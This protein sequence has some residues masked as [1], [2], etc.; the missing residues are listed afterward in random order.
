MAIRRVTEPAEV[1]VQ[2]Q[3]MV[4]ETLSLLTPY[5]LP[6]ERKVRIGEPGDGSYVIVDRLHK[7]QPVMSFGVGP[8][9]NFEIGMAERGHNVFMF[10]H[11]IAEPP[12]AHPRAVWFC[13]GVAST[14]NAPLRL[15]T[16]AEHMNKLP[17]GCEPPILKMDIE[18]DEWSVL[19]SASPD[20]L[21]R[22]DQITFELHGLERIEDP[23]FNVIARKVFEILAK[24]FTL[25]HVHANNFCTVRVLAGCFPVP[26]ALEL[27]YI[28]SSLVT[29]APSRTIYPTELDAP[30]F[31][32][33]PELLLWYFP[34][35]PGS[36]AIDFTRQASFRN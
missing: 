26:E 30:N 9:I 16:L 8:S 2:R 3:R 28:K 24:D 12:A 11:T 22:F 19:G 5:D 36:N 15:F 35:L 10:D 33:F 29:R 27:T 20:L 4:F 31:H 17:T 34:F 14:S 18:G 25:C 6:N 21:A 7:S 23:A 13:E 32:H 1:G